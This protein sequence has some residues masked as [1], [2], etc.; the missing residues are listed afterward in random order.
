MAVTAG[1]DG[2]HIAGGHTSCDPRR[3][4]AD[5][6]Y[7]LGSLLQA[8]PNKSTPYGLPV[9]NDCLSCVVSEERLF[10]QLSHGVLTEFSHIRHSVTYPADAV[11]YVEGGH[12]Q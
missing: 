5:I 11:L 7:R 3:D 1:C 10:C 12:P 8:R 2:G 4:A 9:L 6:L